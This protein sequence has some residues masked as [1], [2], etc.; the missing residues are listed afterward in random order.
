[1]SVTMNGLTFEGPDVRKAIIIHIIGKLLDATW[2][3]LTMGSIQK[4]PVQY[5][6]Q[7]QNPIL[8]WHVVN[9]LIVLNPEAMKPLISGSAP[10]R[11]RKK[12]LALE[13]GRTDNRRTLETLQDTIALIVLWT[14]LVMLTLGIR[15]RDA[16]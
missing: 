15:I 3:I 2:V 11:A 12:L 6:M 8:G 9:C 5:V 13:R 4:A 14:A 10:R 7:K 1:M 16:L